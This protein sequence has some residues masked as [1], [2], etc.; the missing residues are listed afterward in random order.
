M[1]EESIRQQVFI[2]LDDNQKAT[3]KQ[4]YNAFPNEKK[5]KLRVYKSQYFNELSSVG[6]IGQNV[7][8]ESFTFGKKLAKINQIKAYLKYS[9][10]KK[11]RD[12]KIYHIFSLLKTFKLLPLYILSQAISLARLSVN[13]EFGLTDPICYIT[14]CLNKGEY[15]I[16]D[17]SEFSTHCFTS[18][19]AIGLS[20]ES[21]LKNSI[22]NI[23]NWLGLNIT[24]YQ[25]RKYV[26][27]HDIINKK[28]QEEEYL[29][30]KGKLLIEYLPEILGI[31]FYKK[32]KS[33]IIKDLAKA[34]LQNN[35]SKNTPISLYEMVERYNRD[36]DYRNRPDE[37]RIYLDYEETH[38]FLKNK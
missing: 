7:E 21:W 24:Y 19:D 13:E 35:M 28:Q 26:G 8:S 16:N 11:Q 3:N 36:L 18:L 22:L 17:I 34:S 29:A 32:D 5:D 15:S 27:D 33:L 4:I 23:N 12:S 6:I 9:E 20:H 10:L 25:G 2:F 30:I 1:I 31:F 14:D 38:E 37:Y